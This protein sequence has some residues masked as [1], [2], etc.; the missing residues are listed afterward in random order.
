MEG[1]LLAWAESRGYQVGWAPAAIVSVVRQDI[2]GR[3]ASGA[4][5]SDFA[6]ENLG[7]TYLDGAETDDRWRVLVVLMPRPAHRVG[8]VVGGRH[9]EAIV[10]PTYL[11]YRPTFEAVRGEL[12]SRVLIGAR[13]ATLAVPL[14]LLAARMGLVRY[15][16]NN[17]AYSAIAGSYMQILGYLTDAALPVPT[18][19]QPSEPAL[20]A[21]CERCHACERACP[22]GAI[23]RTDVPIVVERCLTIVN[24]KLGTWPSWVPS[25][26]H[27][28]LIG[29]LRCQEDCPA[30]GDLETVPSGV[31]FT[32]E[33][34][35]ALLDAC[36]KQASYSAVILSKLQA[37]VGPHEAPVIGRNLAALLANEGGRRAGRPRT[38]PRARA[39]RGR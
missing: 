16:R 29:C 39:G 8:F 2:E 31:E 30:N 9:V 20:L 10:P 35:R 36:G 22:T 23:Q 12:E 7:F 5:N 37:I 11:R 38:P 28:C 21:R 17:V 18:S 19:W 13:V 32:E 26:A 14:K 1:A 25:S 27:D 33:E 34:T 4:I 24:E 6:R 15:G 3:L